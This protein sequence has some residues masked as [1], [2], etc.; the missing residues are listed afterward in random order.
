MSGSDPTEQLSQGYCL[1]EWNL[2]FTG[3]AG[4]TAVVRAGTSP[5]LTV[6]MSFYTAFGSEGAGS[7]ER[8]AAVSPPIGVLPNTTISL[9]LSSCSGCA[10]LQ[11]TF[12]AASAE[13]G[14]VAGAR[15]GRSR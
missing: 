9:D 13:A 5:V 6:D 8:Y 14:S 2:F 3:E 7:G 1:V 10:A 4:G 15:A 11:V 12:G